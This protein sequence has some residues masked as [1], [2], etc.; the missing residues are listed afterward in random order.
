MHIVCKKKQFLMLVLPQ[1]ST[2]SDI[3]QRFG[4]NY[5]TIKEIPFIH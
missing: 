5:V 1:L 3:V 4:V 2:L